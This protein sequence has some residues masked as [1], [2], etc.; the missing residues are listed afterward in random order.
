MLHYKRWVLWWKKHTVVSWLNARLWFL[1]QSCESD[2]IPSW[3]WCSG[4]TSENCVFAKHAEASCQT[5]CVDQEARSDELSSC[6]DGEPFLMAI[7]KFTLSNTVVWNDIQ[8]WRD[9]GDAVQPQT[10][11]RIR[12]W[13]LTGLPIRQSKEASNM[14]YQG[15]TNWHALVHLL[16]STSKVG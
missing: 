9:E 5:F 8:S 10:K 13:A 1:L 12:T 7:R 6:G 11:Q 2:E 15:R 16:T 3:S 14:P 4:H